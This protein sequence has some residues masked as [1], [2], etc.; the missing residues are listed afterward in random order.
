MKPGG[1]LML[2]VHGDGTRAQFREEVEA[3]ISAKG[4][5]YTVG[6]T[7]MFKFDG[8][9]DYYQTTHH[10]RAYIEERWSKFFKIV[11]Y[12]ERGINA[13]QDAVILLNQ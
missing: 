9:P 13:H 1:V 6:Q 5:L 4:F 11:G 3:L 2:S 10:S 12:M 7:G 8:L